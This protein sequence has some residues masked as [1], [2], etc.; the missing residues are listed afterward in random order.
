MVSNQLKQIEYFR[1]QSKTPVEEQQDKQ[2]V[3]FTSD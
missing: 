3:N 1:R 2:F